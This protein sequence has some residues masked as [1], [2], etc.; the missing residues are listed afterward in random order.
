[1]LIH[2]SIIRVISS[3][4]DHELCMHLRA[5]SGN[6]PHP[7]A[8]QPVIRSVFSR[9]TWGETFSIQIMEYVLGVMY[10]DQHSLLESIL[11]LVDNWVKC[12]PILV[13]FLKRS[14]LIIS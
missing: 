7:C 4:P 1:M 10:S 8:G 12:N 6:M 2:P 13:R 3:N 11:F 14:P 5:S 9:S